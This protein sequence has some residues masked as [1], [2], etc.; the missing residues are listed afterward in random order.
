[1]NNPAL[2]IR[3][4]YEFYWFTFKNFCISKMTDL[5]TQITNINNNILNW[6]FPEYY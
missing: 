1:M 2:N 5:K 4:E 3:F 6:V